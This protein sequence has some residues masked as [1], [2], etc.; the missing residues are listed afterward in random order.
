M[1]MDHTDLI[2]TL[3]VKADQFNDF[4]IKYFPDGEPA[5]LFEATK[6]LPSGG[7]KRLRPV[8]ALLSC[9]SISQNCYDV[10]PFAAA[11]ELVHNF[12]L[13]HDD[14]M[15]NST[16]RRNLPTVH[17]KYGEPTAILA[18]DYLFAKAF[19]AMH[20]LNVDLDLY[21]NLN[22]GLIECILAICEGQQLDMI[23]EHRATI[24]ETEYMDMIKKKTAVLFSLASYGGAEIAGADTTMVTAM[25][26]YGIYLG[27]AFQ[28]WDD[29]LD[30]SSDEQTLG[31][32]IG[33]DIRNGKKTLIAVNALQIATGTQK[34]LLQQTFGNPNATELDIHQVFSLFKDLKSI[35]YARKTAMNFNT[36]AKQ[37]LG[38]LPETN[39]KQLLYHLTDYAIQRVT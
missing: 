26:N 11:L 35:E 38:L 9:E 29:Y 16:L 7:G 22:H 8:L 39:T 6:H 24:T 28:I 25:K 20:D 21:K 4:W 18:G 37:C 30:L 23:F 27:L 13:V 2:T 32:D 31:K 19:E 34:T 33:N 15:D 17:V 10:L 3:K 12:S 14:I 5:S 1:I 36:K